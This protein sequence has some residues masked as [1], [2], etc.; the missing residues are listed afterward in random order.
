MYLYH[1]FLEKIIAEIK[2][3]FPP[4]P[5]EPFFQWSNIW[6]IILN[7]IGGILVVL[8]VELFRL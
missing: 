1:F 2:I 6:Q 3:I 7:I 5:R 4:A 8:S